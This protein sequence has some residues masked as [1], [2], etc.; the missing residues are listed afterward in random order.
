M[1][2][3]LLSWKSKFLSIDRRLTFIKSILG[4]LAIFTLS[5]YKAPKKVLKEMEKIKSNFLWGGSE[6]TRCIHWERWD[7][8]CLPKEN[9]G[10]GVRRIGDFNVVLLNKWNWRMLMEEDNLW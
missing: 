5:F 7:D 3:R 2:N 1:R 6:E 10:L 4:S 8:V 9:G